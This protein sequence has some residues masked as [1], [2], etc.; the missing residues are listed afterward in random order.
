MVVLLPH[1]AFMMTS[2][3]TE[4]E[5]RFLY[6]MS[7]RLPRKINWSELFMSESLC[8]FCITHRKHYSTE[9]LM[10]VVKTAPY[11]AFVLSNITA[12]FRRHV[13][14]SKFILES[15]IKAHRPLPILAHLFQLYNR[16]CRAWFADDFCD[17]AAGA[18]NTEALEWLRNPH[19][20]DGR[21]PWTAV[22]CSVAAKYGHIDMLE[23]LRDSTFDGG[24]CPWG[25]HTCSRAVNMGQ[26]EAL[27]WL[28][29]PKTGGGVCPWHK[30]ACL[31]S[32]RFFGYTAM[33]KWIDAHPDDV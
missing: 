8:R 28:R 17:C 6:D 29:N 24:I 2:H 25:L 7:S 13:E 27:I 5:T 18:N 31:S 32:A 3:L 19:T 4:T 16:S 9:F 33:A 12:R 1:L 23:R 11:E 15:A 14:T 26:L 20:G 21:Y 10:A 22:T 30:E